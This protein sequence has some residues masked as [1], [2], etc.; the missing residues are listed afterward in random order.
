MPAPDRAEH[1]SFKFICTMGLIIF[2]S[3]NSPCSRMSQKYTHRENKYQLKTTDL[4]YVHLLFYSLWKLHFERG[5]VMVQNNSYLLK[6]N[7]FANL[8]GTTDIS[9]PFILEERWVSA[10]LSPGALLA[11]EK[12]RWI[13]TAQALTAISTEEEPPPLKKKK[14]QIQKLY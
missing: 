10:H 2:I 5:K 8:S 14:K 13:S 9:I 1:W 6:H 4:L 3:I 11:R 7:T 12:L